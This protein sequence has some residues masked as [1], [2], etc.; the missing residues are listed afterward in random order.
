MLREVEKLGGAVIDC[1]AVYNE[2]LKRDTALQ[3][4]LEKEFGLL[5]D[6]M[7]AIDRKKLGEVVFRDPAK[8]ESLNAIAWRSVT[9]RVGALLE[10]FRE[11]GKG[12]A[13]VDAIALL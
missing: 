10:E 12:L 1:D 13:A 6:E 3:N 5:M 4:A 7:G 11:Q 2:L 9:D 8:L